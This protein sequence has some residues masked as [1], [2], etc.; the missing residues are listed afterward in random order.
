MMIE[1][2]FSCWADVDLPD[3]ASFGF[4][5]RAFEHLESIAALIETN[6]IHYVIDQ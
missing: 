2:S 4:V 5:G 6:L 1:C 3:A